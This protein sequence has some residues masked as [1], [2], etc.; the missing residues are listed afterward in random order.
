AGIGGA[1]G[2]STGRLPTAG[3]MAASGISAT[4]GASAEASLGSG[5]LSA[6]ASATGPTASFDL[7]TL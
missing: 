7:D 5:G 3:A 4:G 2:A 1:A 6:S